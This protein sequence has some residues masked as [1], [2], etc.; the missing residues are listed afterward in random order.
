MMLPNGQG[1][2]HDPQMFEA[3]YLGN[4]VKY[5]VDFNGPPIGDHMLRVLW[6]RDQQRNVTAKGLS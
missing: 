1:Q 2:G 3:C 5:R 4:C 6:P